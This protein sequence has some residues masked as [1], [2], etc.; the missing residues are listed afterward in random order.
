VLIC[1]V[2][3]GPIAWIPRLFGKPTVLNVDGLDRK[4]KKWGLLS[5]WVLHFCEVLSAFTSSRIVTDAK[6]MQEY[7]WKNYRR[8]SALI[9]YGAEF[10][11]NNGTGKTFD[12]PAGAFIL[13]VSRLEPENN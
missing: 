12:F 1:N 13:Y 7:Y 10:P 9:A 11:A 4:R 8:A 2:A 3:N 6:L 5:R